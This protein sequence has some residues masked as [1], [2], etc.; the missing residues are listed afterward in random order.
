MSKPKSVRQIDRQLHQKH[1]QILI[2]GVDFP[3]SDPKPY[4]DSNL[5]AIRTR[6][7]ESKSKLDIYYFSSDPEF[8]KTW[9]KFTNI[10]D[11]YKSLRSKITDMYHA[12]I[13]TNAWL[14]YW[15][16]YSQYPLVPHVINRQF[17]VFFNAELPGAALVA[18]N[19]F[20]KAMRP[21]IEFDWYASSLLPDDNNSAALGD[22]YG[23]YEKN[24]SKWL[25]SDTNNGD[26]TLMENILDWEKK[27]GPNSPIGG[28]DF[29]S[30]DAGIDVTDNF[31]E[32]E[33]SNAKL[34]LGCAIAGFI[35]LRIGGTFIAKQYTFFE[36][37]TWNLILIYA[38]LFDKFYICKPLTSRPY[39]SEIYLIGLGFKGFDENI[40]S[41]L[42]SRLKNFN[43][44][45]LI[46]VDAVKVL[47]SD[48]F[49]DICR[50]SRCV[51]NV[52]AAMI[53]E[54]I[55]LFEKYKDNLS[56][57][58]RGLSETKY[59]KISAWLKLYPV[60]QIKDSDQLT[61]NV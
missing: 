18:F 30:H 14:K 6:L 26:A 48:Q 60:K 15:E 33:I 22:N 56:E 42:V 50:F 34:H 39:N 61:S 29:Y 23:L 2:A 25:M 9:L 21:N 52:Q 17:T 10:I 12:V 57:L 44:M 37:I 32:Q 35:T 27:I 53:D 46:N 59:Q 1:L 24:K 40:K 4:M 20:M 16:L 31:N 55:K 5:L 36:T 13:V 51:F 43:T 41:C 45:P 58:T 38:R 8:K 3:I 19:Q 7:N 47:L 11:T 54:N 28:V 49:S